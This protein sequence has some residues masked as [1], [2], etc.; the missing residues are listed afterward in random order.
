MISVNNVCKSYGTKPVL[1]NV[2][3]DF[4]ESRVTSLI[5]PNGAGKSTLL[6]SIGR[7]LDIEQGEILL[8]NTSIRDI[9]LK[10]YAK[11][12]ATMRQFH[13]LNLRLTVRELVAFGRFPYSQGA[14]TK[15]DHRI[16]DEALSFL[17]LQP[18]GNTFIDELSGGQRQMAFLA[19]SIAQQTD[20]LLLDEPLNNLDMKHAVSIMRALRHLCDEHKRTVILVVHDI[21]FA[22]N[23]S[24]NII[25][26]KQGAIH[27]SGSVEDVVTADTLQDLYELNFEILKTSQGVVCNYFNQLGKPK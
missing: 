25:A 26:M 20:Y 10:N 8:R 2:S 11:R 5:G 4:P 19:M 22:A 3:V 27:S 17:V 9:S 16:I 1:K 15:D 12:V 21:N 6:M 13:N 23:Y 18:L 14:L 7:L 24:D